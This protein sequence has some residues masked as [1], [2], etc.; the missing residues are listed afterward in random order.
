M[1]RFCWPICTP[2]VTPMLGDSSFVG[3][4]AGG[5][6]EGAPAT[7]QGGLAASIRCGIRLT[8]L[9]TTA[10]SLVPGSL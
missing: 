4:V 9:A 2:N 1:A 8:G 3:E 10:P 6:G 7:R 5:S